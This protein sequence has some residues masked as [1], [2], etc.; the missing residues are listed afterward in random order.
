MMP[1]RI[2]YTKGQTVGDHGLVYLE[3]IEPHVDP[4]G[5]NERRARFKCSCGEEFGQVVKDVKSGKT[6]SCGCRRSK[7]RAE[8]NRERLGEDNP[9]WKGGV[10]YHYL[11]ATWKGMKQRCLNKTSVSY[12]NYGGR[13]ITIHE[14]WINESAAFIEW[15][16]ENLGPRPDGYSMD[17]I[18]NDGNYEPGN[19]RWADHSTQMKNRRRHNTNKTGG[20]S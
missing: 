15:I 19:L 10:K 3:D 11:Y 7:V 18:G 4:R 9:A 12:C 14:P 2:N 1:A 8:M 13:G 20:Q 16:E 5:K 17:R 6:K